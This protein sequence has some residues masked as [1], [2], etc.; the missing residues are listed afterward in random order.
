MKYGMYVI[1]D[2]GSESCS[3]PFFVQNDFVARR[4][5]AATLRTLPPS[6][7]ADFELM[8]VAVYDDITLETSDYPR[9][10]PTA[11]GS[12]DDI[13]R[14]IELDSSFYARGNIDSAPVSTP[15]VSK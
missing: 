13:K 5:F 15:E 10:Y 12:D 14:M 11:K 3:L 6:C 9:E 2:A 8:Q 4:Q 1:R 7:R